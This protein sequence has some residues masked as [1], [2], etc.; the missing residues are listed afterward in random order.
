[1][2]WHDYC[3]AEAYM[4]WSLDYTYDDN[5]DL[6]FNRTDGQCKTGCAK[7]V[8]EERGFTANGEKINCQQEKTCLRGTKK[9]TERTAVQI[10]ITKILS[11]MDEKRKALRISWFAVILILIIIYTL[12][13]L[14]TQAVRLH[15]IEE[16]HDAVTQKIEEEAAIQ[17]KLQAECE[18]LTDRAYIEQVARDELGLVKEGEVPFISREKKTN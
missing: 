3:D 4:G 6:L 15:A 10:M 16:E 5:A 8:C 17:Q 2:G 1:M 18:Q 7:V 11:Y 9:D 13:M 12:Y 14:L